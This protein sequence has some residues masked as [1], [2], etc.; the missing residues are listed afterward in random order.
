MKFTKTIWLNSYFITILV[1]FFALGS[2]FLYE[3]SK[4]NTTIYQLV[5]EGRDDKIE[6]YCR[7]AR[8]LEEAGELTLAGK[9]IE[10]ALKLKPKDPFLLHRLA[11][12]CIKEKNLAQALE[13]LDEA[14]KLDKHCLAARLD[15][16][17]IYGQGKAYDK[18]LTDY[19]IICIECPR[20]SPLYVEGQLG[21]ALIL[22]EQKASDQAS[23][24][25]YALLQIKNE[26]GLQGKI[27][28]LLGLCQ[29]DLG[30]NQDA[31]DCFTAA[32]RINKEDAKLYYNRALAFYGKM[33]Y[34]DSFADLTKAVQL[35]PDEIQYHLKRALLAKHLAF[36]AIFHYEIRRAQE[37]DPE[38]LELQTLLKEKAELEK[39]N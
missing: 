15:R 1:L 14:L 38:N 28:A 22:R 36:Y 7:E 24:K 31:I 32:L 13:F 17:Y 35:A 10:S 37:L 25:L 18:A 23:E 34:Q 21:Q 2:F 27:F 6:R 5:R 16:A 33:A 3:L 26:A 11:I 30:K 8:T 4:P 12:L 39:K 29:L 9:R 19:R 20:N